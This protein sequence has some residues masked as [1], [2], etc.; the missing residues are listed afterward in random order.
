MRSRV[1]GNAIV[2]TFTLFAAVCVPAFAD[3]PLPPAEVLKDSFPAQKSY[4]PYAGRNF[5]TQ[6]FFGDT[7]VHTGAS[8]DAAR[9]AHD[10]A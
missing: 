9:S 8:M 7:H 10:W 3:E 5:P 6:V 4:S 1:L 2:Q